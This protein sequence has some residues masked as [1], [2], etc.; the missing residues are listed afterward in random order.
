[1][2]V[3]LDN[4][5]LALFRLGRLEEAEVCVR[6]AIEVFSAA[7]VERTHYLATGL[8]NLGVLAREQGRYEESIESFER[9]IEIYR[10]KLG[11][12]DPSLSSSLRGSPPSTSGR[13]VPSERRSCS[14][15]RSRST[16][17]STGPTA[18]RSSGPFAVSL[19]PVTARVAP[20]RR[21]H[22]RVVPSR[23]GRRIGAPRIRS[24]PARWRRWRTCWRR[25]G[26]AARRS[27]RDGG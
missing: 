1:M 7:G 26:G 13:S 23:S 3:S 22:W 17:R 27:S 10:D 21:W 8:H 25:T 18:R 5:A 12:A 9:A 6:R 24:S 11:S 15:K 20:S 16:R 14:R 4:L 2:G 19:A